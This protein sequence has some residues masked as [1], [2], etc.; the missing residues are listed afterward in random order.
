MTIKEKHKGDTYGD[1]IVLYLKL[2]W[3]LHKPAC[4]K[5]DRTIY[6]HEYA[7]SSI[8]HKGKSVETTKI[9]LN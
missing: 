6:T 3:W 2:Q 5:W 9:S 4:D 1:R 8:I 7:H